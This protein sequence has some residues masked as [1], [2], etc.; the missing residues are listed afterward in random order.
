MAL[1]Q[2]LSWQGKQ[3]DSAGNELRENQPRV[4]NKSF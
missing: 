4:L 2:E 3:V 1:N